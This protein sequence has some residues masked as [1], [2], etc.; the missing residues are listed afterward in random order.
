MVQSAAEGQ[1]SDTETVDLNKMKVVMHMLQEEVR[2][3]QEAAGNIRAEVQ[4]VAQGREL[5]VHILQSEVECLSNDLGVFRGLQKLAQ[6]LAGI[7]SSLQIM[8]EGSE[9][10]EGAAVLVHGLVSQGDLN[11]QMGL[12]GK[13]D[14]A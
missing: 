1:D 10:S 11:S 6:E 8:V 3:L 7:V 13:H 12:L 2:V 14:K 4:W 9:L 5:K